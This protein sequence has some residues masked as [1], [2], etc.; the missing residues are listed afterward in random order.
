MGQR[1]RYRRRATAHSSDG[2]SSGSSASSSSQSSASHNDESPPSSGAG[3]NLHE[4]LCKSTKSSDRASYVE[5]AD[6][7]RP[8]EDMVGELNMLLREAQQALRGRLHSSVTLASQMQLAGVRKRLQLLCLGLLQLELSQMAS[9]TQSKRS[10][11]STK[12]LYLMAE[13]TRQTV[14]DAAQSHASASEAGILTDA[15]VLSTL[16]TSQFPQDSQVRAR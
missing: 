16:V 10:V 4:Q 5:P 13:R 15:A 7:A 9:P 1:R 2:S 3:Q 8:A 6:A 11:E 12:Q 14:A